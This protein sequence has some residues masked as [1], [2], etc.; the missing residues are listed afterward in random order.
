M[1]LSFACCP[2]Q[3]TKARSQLTPTSASQ[4][5]AILLPQPSP[6]Y[7]FKTKFKNPPGKIFRLLEL[8]HLKGNS[9]FQAKILTYLL[10]NHY[11]LFIE[12]VLL[13]YPAGVQWHDLGLLKPLSP[14]FKQFSCLNLSN[15]WD[16][17]C[18]PPSLAN[19]I[20]LVETGFCH[21]DQVGLELLTSGD[22][23]SL[24]SRSARITGVSH[25]AW[26]I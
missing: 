23:P 2:G 16:C 17:R 25:C 13:C 9:G 20:F 21:V 7:K 10:K 19:F 18:T 6:K 24:A 15:S 8:T 3:S 1:R 26:P 11:Y 14:G 5:Q 22:L 12:T 4:F